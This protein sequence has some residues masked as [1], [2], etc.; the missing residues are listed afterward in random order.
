M[1]HPLLDYTH[2][3]PWRQAHSLCIRKGLL[4]WKRVISNLLPS[5]VEDSLQ[6]TV[7]FQQQFTPRAQCI[8]PLP[9]WRVDLWQLLSCSQHDSGGGLASLRMALLQCG[10]AVSTSPAP[11]LAAG[12]TKLGRWLCIA[13]TTFELAELCS[14]G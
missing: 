8:T 10:V 14:E 12:S 13:V 5:P 1:H 6:C 11:T 4:K 7:R 9:S 3:I 2:I